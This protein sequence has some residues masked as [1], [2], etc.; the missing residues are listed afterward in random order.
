MIALTYCDLCRKAEKYGFVVME[1]VEPEIVTREEWEQGANVNVRC[2]GDDEDED[3]SD[4][5]GE[6][7]PNPLVLDHCEAFFLSYALGCLV[8]SDGGEELDLGC[9]I[10]VP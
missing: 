6:G 4:G 10:S 9:N 1:E 7:G 8:V 2:P 3:D 5:E